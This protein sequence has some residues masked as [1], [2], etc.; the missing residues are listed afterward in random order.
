M[1]S[2]IARS[3]KLLLSAKFAQGSKYH[4][5]LSDIIQ[6][7]PDGRLRT[8]IG[9]VATSMMP[10]S[11]SARQS[12]SRERRSPAFGREYISNGLHRCNMTEETTP[13]KV[14]R[15]IGSRV[16]EDSAPGDGL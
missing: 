8:N 10:T 2:P 16:D 15:W 9:N 14:T 4:A 6:R 11:P 1:R 5:Q 3:V 13:M 7:V 12:G